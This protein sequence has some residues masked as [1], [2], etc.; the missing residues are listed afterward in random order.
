LLPVTKTM[1]ANAMLKRISNGW[2]VSGIC[3][4]VDTFDGSEAQKE[5]PNGV[6]ERVDGA[7]GSLAQ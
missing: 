3:E 7:C 6:P 5:Q 2:T 4:V 1:E